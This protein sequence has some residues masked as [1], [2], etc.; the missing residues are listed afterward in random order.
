M[1]S[2]KAKTC[3]HTGLRAIKLLTVLSY[4]KRE[5]CKAQGSEERTIKALQTD[6][7]LSE[8]VKE[9]PQCKMLE[10]AVDDVYLIERVMESC[11]Q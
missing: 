7:Y 3:T 1:N 2:S 5:N 10:L 8:A 4:T 11:E 9:Q 6:T